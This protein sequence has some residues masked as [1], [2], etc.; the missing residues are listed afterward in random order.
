MRKLSLHIT[1]FLLPVLVMVFLFPQD[2]MHRYASLKDDC[3]N[4]AAWMYQRMYQNLLPVDIA[5][6]GSSRTMNSL[7]EDEMKPIT[8]RKQLLNFGYCRYGRNL[9]Y[10][11]IKDLIELKHAKTIILEVRQNENPYPH[12]VGPYFAD[13]GDALTSYPFFNPNYLKDW[14]TTLQFKL[15]LLQEK[16]WN[17]AEALQPADADYGFLPNLSTTGSA[18]FEQ[19]KNERQAEQTSGLKRTFE[20]TYPLHY[21][22]KIAQLCEANNVELLFLY[23]PSYGLPDTEPQHAAFYKKHG[24]IITPP[25]AILRDVEMW[26]D[27]N[28][29]N[30]QG[31]WLIS[32]WLGEELEARLP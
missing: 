15:Q 24:D 25:Q 4:R 27:P 7:K 31:A 8:H 2:K 11:F 3:N 30:P 19:E 1:L 29:L 9:H 10:M 18:I 16:I 14:S 21:L 17:T 32:R 23:L 28:H 22:Q 5:F 20:D 6:I 13:N 26:A 12:P